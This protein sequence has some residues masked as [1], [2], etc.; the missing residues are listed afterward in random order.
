MNTFCLL[1]S[2]AHSWTEQINTM[3]MFLLGMLWEIVV[4]VQSSGARLPITVNMQMLLK[5]SLPHFLH[6]SKNV[7]GI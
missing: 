6:K 7:S 3:Q 4:N 5:F 1:Q 2:T